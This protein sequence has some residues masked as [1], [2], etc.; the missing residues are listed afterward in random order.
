MTLKLLYFDKTA[1]FLPTMYN[2]L[3]V[4]KHFILI[5]EIVNFLKNYYFFNLINPKHV[6]KKNTKFESLKLMCE[7][8]NFIIWR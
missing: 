5:N 1:P 6:K 2:I 8:R 7:I 3:S 4:Y